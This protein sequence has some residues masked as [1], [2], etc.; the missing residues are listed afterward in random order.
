MYDLPITANPRE[1]RGVFKRL[2]PAINKAFMKLKYSSSEKCVYKV[3]TVDGLKDI[4]CFLFGD[5]YNYILHKRP[6]LS[7]PG[8]LNGRANKKLMFLNGKKFGVMC[9]IP[10]FLEK[11]KVAYGN[12][13]IEISC[14][15]ILRK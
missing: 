1:F 11:F 8:I 14:V 9:I 15:R 6:P 2:I 5:I 7:N 12:C 13:S 3:D 10:L 4:N